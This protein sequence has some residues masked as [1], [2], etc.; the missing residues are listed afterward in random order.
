MSDLI[1]WGKDIARVTI[2][3]NNSK[4][5]GR[6]P[7]PSIHSDTVVLSRYL[8]RDGT[9]WFELN[10]KQVSKEEVVKLMREHGIDAD[11]LLIVM[12]QG[13]VEE[14]AVATS[15]QRLR[16]VEGA[17]G[18]SGYREKILEARKR[19]EELLSEEESVA[20]LLR[21]AE[22]TL[23]HWKAEYERLLRKRE[24]LAKR[25]LL[26]RELAWA[27]VIK[28]ERAVEQLKIELNRVRA[29]VEYVESKIE[30]ARNRTEELADLLSSLKF[31]QRRCF[32]ELLQSESEKGKLEGQV[33]SLDEIL[34]W[35][36]S[37]RG[38][39]KEGKAR[40]AKLKELL[41]E[42]RK[43]ARRTAKRCKELAAH[44]LKIE[45]RLDRAY[46]NYVD[47][48]IDEAVLRSKREMLLSEISKLESDIRQTTKDIEILEAS[49]E[50]V[51][52]RV[53]T[54]R[55][56]TEV[57]EDLKV[58]SA[59]LM[60]L[61]DVSEDAERVYRRYR[62]L[63][64]K[65]KE[66][67]RVVSENRQRALEDLELRMRTWKQLLQEFVEGVNPIYRTILAEVD[68]VGRIRLANLDDI[69]RAGLEL[70]LGFRGSEP[71]LFDAYTQS[72]GEKSVATVA[73]LLALQRY[74]KSPFRAVDEFDVHM[75][76]RNREAIYK[77]F[78]S[79]MRESPNS[80]YLVITPSP[81][82]SAERW[83]HVITVQNVR[84]VSM[85]RVVGAD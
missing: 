56:P 2:V 9:Y 73:F 81:V 39:T 74:V 80:Q 75:D 26:E 82:L 61:A 51:G 42:C 18:I 66:K 14:F 57:S 21:N 25:Q 34:G 47:K 53:E 10:R 7:I 68:A 85:A 52:P 15:Q 46:E 23:E 29:K 27:K 55:T 65:L 32:H 20:S 50:Q 83:V 28:K 84:G 64:E 62:E 63:Y 69:E 31:E 22:E 16:M 77:F 49:A 60:T 44:L 58:T 70:Y 45:K 36:K 59:Y 35:L 40:R 54:V 33:L 71:V 13:M 11:N 19:L 79:M 17:I 24:L 78:V 41:K 67:L 38:L 48:R 5:G 1:R 3:F 4:R 37:E 43:Q 6:R 76:P 30:E 72:G 8:R 12:H